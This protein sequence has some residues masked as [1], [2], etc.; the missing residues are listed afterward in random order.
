L[1][2]QSMQQRQE[3]AD[4]VLDLRGRLGGEGECGL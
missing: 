3:E 4:G 1:L 2:P